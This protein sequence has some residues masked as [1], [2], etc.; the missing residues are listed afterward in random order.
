M[1]SG[2]TMWAIGTLI[3]LAALANGVRFARKPA[4]TFERI[5]GGRGTPSPRTLG[6][7]IIIAAPLFW[8]FWTAL[9]FGLFGPVQNIQTIQLH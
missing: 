5:P 9:W 4:D 8:L 3:C 7:V 2:W 1:T 6:R